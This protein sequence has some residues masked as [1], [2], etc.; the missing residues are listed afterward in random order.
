MKNTFLLIG[1]FLLFAFPMSAQDITPPKTG[2]VLRMENTNHKLAIGEDFS[3]EIWLIRSKANKKTTYEGL[4]AN[5]AP[6]VLVTFKPDNQQ[7]DRYVMNISVAP[8]VNP[9]KYT[10]LVK[11]KGKNAHKLKGTTFSLVVTEQLNANN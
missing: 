4:K 8:A 10:V 5:A 7:P 9:G 2:A 3:S 1:A 11:G 6:G